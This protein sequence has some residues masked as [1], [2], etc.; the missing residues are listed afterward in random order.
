MPL[1]RGNPRLKG[2]RCAFV[3]RSLL[4]IRVEVIGSGG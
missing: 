3:G 2:F 1:Q 4:S